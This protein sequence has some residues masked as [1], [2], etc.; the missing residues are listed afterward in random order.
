VPSKH[1]ETRLKRE[2]VIWLATVGRDGQPHVVPV[3]FWWDGKSFL[4]YAVPGQKVRDIQANPNVALHLNTDPVG[5]DVVRIDGT[6]MVDPRQAPAYR[7]P[8]YVRK[9]REQMRGLDWTPKVFSDK[10]HFALRVKPA[11]FHEEM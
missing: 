3:W 8:A 9:Y 2:L 10:Y 5:G 4:I 1:V 6:A 7:V 11:R